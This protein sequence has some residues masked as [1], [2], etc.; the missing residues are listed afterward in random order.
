MKDA[1]SSNASM[2]SSD[3]LIT[4]TRFPNISKTLPRIEIPKFSGDYNAWRS[5]HDL[6]LS[7]VGNNMGLS[8]VEKMHYLKTSLIGDAAKI[9]I[10]LPVSESS[11]T[12]AWNTLIHR[13]ENKRVLISSQLDKLFSIKRI[14][15]KSSKELNTF[16]STILE[17]LGALKALGCPIE[18][19]DLIL[20]HHLSRLLDAETREAW[21]LK[22]GTST[23][24]PT[25]KRFEEFLVGQSRA[26]ERLE[27][28]LPGH[29]NK[30]RSSRPSKTQANPNSR[31]LIAV[32]SKSRDEQFCPL[33]KSKHYLITCKEFLAMTTPRRRR[34]IIQQKLCFNCLGSHMVN[35]CPTTRR[36]KKCGK[37][38]HTLI[39]DSF[40]SI[41]SESV[42]K[43]TNGAIKD[44]PTSLPSSSLDLP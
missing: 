3:L 33:C 12:I 6:F 11:F 38:H 30:I 32:T 7:M 41:A 19:W 14:Q 27:S 29:P 8:N 26:W 18:S 34:F 28:H 43:T 5:F 20:I 2:Q 13:Y 4:N 37:K 42:T 22:L 1:R 16:I 10:N 23:N 35:V 40:K 21:E 36:C 17:S 31:S 15:T 25:F 39:H 24:Y 44:N 9:I